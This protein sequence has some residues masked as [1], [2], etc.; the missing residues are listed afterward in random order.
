MAGHGSAVCGEVGAGLFG[1]LLAADGAARA[2]R[3]QAAWARADAAAEDA[4]HAL[5]Q[6]LLRAQARER[7]LLQEIAALRAEAQAQRSRACRAEGQ[8]LGLRRRSAA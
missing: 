7:E 5:G 2:A 1:A 8:L 6:R 3:E 4:V